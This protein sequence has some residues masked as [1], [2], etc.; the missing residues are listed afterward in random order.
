MCTDG[1]LVPGSVADALRVAHAS[2]DYLNGPDAAL[3]DPAALGGVLRSLGELQAKFAAAQAGFLRRFDAADAHDADG[4]GTSAAW[5]AAM[6]RLKGSDAKAAVAR[7]RALGRHPH[8]AEAMAAGQISPSWVAEIDRLTRKLPAELRAETDQILLQ[9]AAAGASL[10]DLKLLAAC[11]VEQYLARQP[12]PDDDDD[13]D[14]RFVQVGTTFGGASC[15]RGNLTPECTAAVQAVLDAMGKKRGPEDN[16]TE[17]QRFHDALQEACE[18]LIRARMVPG[19][20]GADTQ[21]IAHIPLAE[22]RGRDG[23]SAVEAAWIAG[24]LGGPGYLTG[25][26]AEAAACDALI[27][28]VVTGHPDMTVIDQIIELALTAAG[29]G[30]AAAPPARA[31]GPPRPGRCR[32]RRGRRCGTRS[33][34]WPSTSSPARPASPR[35]CAPGCWSPRSTPPACRWTSGTPT[36]SRRTSAAPSRCA[37]RGAPGPAAAGPPACATCTTSCTRRTAARPRSAPAFSC[38]SSTTTSASTGGAGS[39]SCT[40]TAPPR[41]AAPT[42][43]SSAATHHPHSA[44]ANPGPGN[45]ERRLPSMR[46]RI[47]GRSGL[48]RATTSKPCRANVDAT[49]GNR[50]PVCPGTVVSTGYASRAGAPASAAASTA[51]G[52]SASMTPR[53]RCVRRT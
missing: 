9:A 21:V 42:G 48:W 30:R 50:L 20:A 14:D 12:S 8:L 36:A 53:P 6:T 45:A 40:R 41:P 49:P 7:M 39:S 23:A 11:A 25:K 32:R 35:C 47:T 17:G 16:R 37:T 10:D 3:L 51:A 52:I 13:F 46:L 29:T 27:V 4:Y 24:R 31:A 15:V 22:L 43:R 34:G 28:P 44:P 18:L 5:L 1:D 19:R 2:L 38:A 26:D 33:P